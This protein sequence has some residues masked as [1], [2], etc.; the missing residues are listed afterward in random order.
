[1][2]FTREP[3]V[4]TIITPKDGCKLVIR[5]SKSA[6]QEEY[7][8]DAVEVVSFGHALFYRSIERPKAFLVPASDYE[9]LEVR[10]ARMVLKNV[11]VERTIKIG[12]GREPPKPIREAGEKLEPAVQPAPVPAAAEN[13][14]ALEAK[15]EVR[16]DKKRDKRRHYR[17]RRGHEEEEEAG[18]EDQESVE[19]ED[20]VKIEPSSEISSEKK[21]AEEHGPVLVP[22]ISS[23]LPPPPTLISESI[24]RYRKDALFKGAFFVKDSEEQQ[25][26]VLEGSN[27]PIGNE[28]NLAVEHSEEVLEALDMQNISLEPSAYGSFDAM[29]EEDDHVFFF[30]EQDVEGK[31]EAHFPESSGLEPQAE[32]EAPVDFEQPKEPEQAVD[33]KPTA[34]S[35]PK[36][37]SEPPEHLSDRPN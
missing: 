7:F 4:E 25:E 21:E 14:P 27:I 32:F 16:L 24:A 8:V 36:V 31:A 13:A 5:S 35:E 2:D 37:D 10:E 34:D 15:G 33:S 23:L 30:E 9:V 26:A 29:E 17:R 11:G 19:K 22:F 18:N 1:M 12:G 28:Q 20:G 6:G 3:I